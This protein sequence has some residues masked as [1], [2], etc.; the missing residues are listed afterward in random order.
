[1][2]HAFQRGFVHNVSNLPQKS[3]Q[4]QGLFI[5]TN[6]NINISNENINTGVFVGNIFKN[7]FKKIKAF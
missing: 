1:M 5:Y 2:L 4:F 7:N 3:L 6:V